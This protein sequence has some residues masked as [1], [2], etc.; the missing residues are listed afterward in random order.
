MKITTE[1]LPQIIMAH[2]FNNNIDEIKV[3]SPDS[4]DYTMKL[5]LIA[6]RSNDEQGNFVMLKLIKGDID[7]NGKNGL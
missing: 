5:K 4:D 6:Y 7:E 3:R 2:M 1:Q